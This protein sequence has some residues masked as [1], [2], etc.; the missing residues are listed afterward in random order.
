MLLLSEQ[1]TDQSAFRKG[2][3]GYS[4]PATKTGATLLAF[5][6]PSSPNLPRPQQAIRSS[7]VIPQ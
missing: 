7:S 5:P 6:A 1:Q 4:T 2:A 3:A